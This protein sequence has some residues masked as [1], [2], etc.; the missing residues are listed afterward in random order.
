[1]ISDGGS[2]DN[3]VSVV[4]NMSDTFPFPLRVVNSKPGKTS[5]KGIYL[6]KAL[7]CMKFF[8]YK[9]KC[10]FIKETDTFGHIVV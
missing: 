2:K 10:F 6:S 1:M 3:T 4:K 9:Q 7:T 8:L 5:I